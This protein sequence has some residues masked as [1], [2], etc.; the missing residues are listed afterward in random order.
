MKIIHLILMSGFFVAVI[1]F[2]WGFI[3]ADLPSDFLAKFVKYSKKQGG[4]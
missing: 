2:V 3:A 4:K 1:L